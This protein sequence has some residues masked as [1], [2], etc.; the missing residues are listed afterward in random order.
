M[1]KQHALASALANTLRQRGARLVLTRM[2]L[3]YHDTI[4]SQAESPLVNPGRRAN[5]AGWSWRL[6]AT[7]SC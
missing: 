2:T 6:I 7:P 5:Y 3:V 1:R 4:C